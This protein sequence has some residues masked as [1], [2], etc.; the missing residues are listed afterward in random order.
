MD[1]NGQH[2]YYPPGA[3]CRAGTQIQYNFAFTNPAFPSVRKDLDDFVEYFAQAYGKALAKAF[4]QGPHPLVFL[5]LYQG[6]LMAYKGVAP[7]VD[8]FWVTEDDPTRL[9][10]IYV[11]TGRPVIL[12]D[13]STANP[14]SPLFFRGTV[15]S[16]TY[17]PRANLTT[18]VAAGMEYIFRAPWQVTFP[19]TGFA[20]G[21]C[22]ALKGLSPNPRIVA[23]RWNSF[24][25]RGNY[26]PC[27]DRGTHFELFNWVADKPN[28]PRSQSDRAR[29]IVE[30]LKT[31]LGLRGEDGNAF[32]VGYEHW[33]LYDNSPSDYGEIGNFGL[34]T[35]EDNAYDGIEAH[36]ATGKD[37][38][39][40]DRG[41]EERDYGNLL[42]PLSEYLRTLD[43]L[44]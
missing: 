37:S 36:R 34:V 8:G 9:K 17:D 32:V 1:E 24:D 23:I 31:A 14:D 18:V 7:Y 26:V 3:P 15:S 12:A 21:S 38:R 28:R 44:H 27:I 42:G 5:P 2:I 22:L 10:Q 30:R 33:D 25:L 20:S 19:D 40:Y 41:G 39:G 13:Y 35:L 11:S 43:E 29:Y 4:A 6:P 16:L